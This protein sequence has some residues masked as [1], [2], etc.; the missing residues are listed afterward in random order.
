[1]E[2]EATPE[3]KT[4]EL[5]VPPQVLID[6]LYAQLTQANADNIVLQSKVKYA[7]DIINELEIKLE[8]ALSSS[9]DEN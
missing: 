9:N 7:L 3:A 6:Q 2:Q 4:R 5:N 1:M 8:K